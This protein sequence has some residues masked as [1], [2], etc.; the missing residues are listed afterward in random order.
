MASRANARESNDPLQHEKIVSYYD[1]IRRFIRDLECLPLVISPTSPALIANDQ[2][3]ALLE[4]GI[5]M[6]PCYRSH[7]HAFRTSCRLIP[8]FLSGSA[9]LEREIFT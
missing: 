6:Y 3:T 9:L 8:C 7:K 5:F 1:I 4:R 2:S